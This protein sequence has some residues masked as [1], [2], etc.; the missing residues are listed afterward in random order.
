MYNTFIDEHILIVLLLF[1]LIIYCLWILYKKSNSKKKYIYGGL[2]IF[3]IPLTL[4]SL[5]KN[6]VFY[7]PG[8]TIGSIDGWLSFLG[9][10]TGALLALGGIWWQI[11]VSNDKKIE[12]DNNKIIIENKNHKKEYIRCLTYILNIVGKNLDYLSKN[13]KSL[14]NSITYHYMVARDIDLFDYFPFND[15]IINTFSLNFVNNNHSCILYLVDLINK[16]NNSKSIFY[17]DLAV[18][19]EYLSFFNNYKSEQYPEIMM[20]FKN[21]IRLSM[22]LIC[23]ENKIYIK[24]YAWD[25]NCFKEKLIKN[26]SEET[27]INFKRFSEPKTLNSESFETLYYEYYFEIIKVINFL[28]KEDLDFKK[29]YPNFLNNFT[30][31]YHNDLYKKE[32]IENLELLLNECKNEIEKFIRINKTSD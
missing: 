30:R 31:L 27:F 32:L 12:D 26:P 2:L 9:G 3:I 24:L 16:I 10:Y 7:I 5:L 6:I 19:N 13:K 29:Y 18:K 25:T 17:N 28:S 22:C 15:N 14:L 20:I 21:F 23:P 11:K 4:V 8:S 1:L